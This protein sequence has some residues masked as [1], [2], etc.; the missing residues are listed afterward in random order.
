MMKNHLSS[1]VRR[2][3]ETF[4]D[5]SL[6]ARNLATWLAKRLAMGSRHLYDPHSKGAEAYWQL[7]KEIIAHDTKGIGSGVGGA[8][9]S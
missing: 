3:F 6:W 8:A 9:L 4:M 7:A 1:A 5:N 2:T